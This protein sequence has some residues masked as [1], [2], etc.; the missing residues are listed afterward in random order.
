M[1]RPRASEEGPSARERIEGAFWEL[2]EERPFEE[3]TVTDIA[4]AAHVNRNTFYYHFDGIEDLARTVIETMI[5]TQFIQALIGGITM[6]HIDMALIA[7]DDMT[8]MPYERVRL[9]VRSRSKWLGGLVRDEVLG[10]W[11][12]R[13]GLDSKA[14]T[15]RDWCRINFVWNGILGVL[16]TDGLE[17]FEDYCA[18][19]DSG[20]ADAGASLMRS[21]LAEHM[22]KGPAGA[23]GGA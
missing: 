15:E 13:L 18:V 21:V 11:I 3:L 7:G 5:P 23:A 9:L 14:F 8:E 20:I 1:G 2:L 10:L 12:E 22:G 17:S 16:A 6:G 19:L 4:A